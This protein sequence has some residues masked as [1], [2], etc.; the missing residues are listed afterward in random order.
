MAGGL[1]QSP[2]H[3]STMASLLTVSKTEKS[4][5]GRYI[6]TLKE[7][8]SLAAH[9]SSTQASIASTTSN[10]THELD[11]INGYAGEFTESD[12]DDLRA[13]PE[14]DSIEED[15][16]SRTCYETQSVPLPTRAT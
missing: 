9:V 11:I 10:I 6:I 2:A 3:F 7:D 15:G 16:I 12:L 13:N 5:P 14:I 1:Q 8:V 4:T